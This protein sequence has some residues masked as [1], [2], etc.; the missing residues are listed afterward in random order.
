[1]PTITIAHTPSNKVLLRLLIDYAP[2]IHVAGFNI[3]DWQMLL[4]ILKSNLHGWEALHS[5]GRLS[6]WEQWLSDPIQSCIQAFE[7]GGSL[8]Q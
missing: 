1:M 3:S 7:T 8:W 4:Q 5:S 2:S 6:V